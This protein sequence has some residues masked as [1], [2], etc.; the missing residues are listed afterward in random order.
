MI[1]PAFRICLP[2]PTVLVFEV[3][4]VFLVFLGAAALALA[5]IP[6]T[7]TGRERLSLRFTGLAIPA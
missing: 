4:L 6:E 2:Q 1:V 7:V 5:F 3:F